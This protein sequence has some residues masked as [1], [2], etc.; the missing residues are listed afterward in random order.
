[1]VTRRRVLRLA[2][3][4]AVVGL[5]WT[6]GLMRFA[7]IEL[8]LL[9]ILVAPLILGLGID[10]A[11]HLLNRDREDPADLPSTVQAVSGAI[12]MTSA[13]TKSAAL[14]SQVR[15]MSIRQGRTT[16]AKRAIG[17]SH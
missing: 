5:V 10:D 14:E 8:N 9:T 1:M 17:E 7:G 11:I 6:L 2:L 3:V 4:P 13:T 12:L 15:P 16:C